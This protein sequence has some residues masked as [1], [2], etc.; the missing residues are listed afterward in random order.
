MTTVSAR[1]TEVL[2]ERV[3][4]VFA[5]MGNGNAISSTPSREPVCA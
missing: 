1:I 4:E 2:D 3:E 5:L